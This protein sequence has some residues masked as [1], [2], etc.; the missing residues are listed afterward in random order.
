MLPKVSGQEMQMFMVL[1]QI[2]LEERM[3][4]SGGIKSLQQN[5][6]AMLVSLRVQIGA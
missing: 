2:Q 3:P 6:E 4:L 5:G 1:D